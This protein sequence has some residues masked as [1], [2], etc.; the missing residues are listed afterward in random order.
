MP[1]LAD[2]AITPDVFDE[3]SY[4][5]HDAC[6]ARLD[7]I[8]EAMMTEGL[9]RDLRN[10]DWGALFKS[11]DRPW[12][13]RGKEHVKKLAK[14]GRLVRFRPAPLSAPVDDLGWCAEAL[15]TH[16]VRPLRGGVIVTESIKEKS[17]DEPLVSRIDKLSSAPWWAARGP[18]VKLQRTLADYQKH[19]DPV[20]PL[21]E[22]DPVHRSASGSREVKIRRLWR[23]ACTVRETRA[24]A[25]N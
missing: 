11:G 22:F 24:S 14:Q 21:F 12:H 4:P 15:A 19:L 2:Y 5:N 17:A 3:T 6:A 23:T 7:T 10:G 1:L 8:H 16:T 25:N 20:L 13:R 18:S 9:V